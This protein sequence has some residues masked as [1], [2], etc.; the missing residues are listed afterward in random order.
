VARGAWRVV[1]VNTGT[2]GTVSCDHDI[3]ITHR[4][5]N[6]HIAHRY[7]PVLIAHRYRHIHS[8]I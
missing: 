3:H 5:Y 7:C 1:Q 8:I 2:R 4:Y 6:I